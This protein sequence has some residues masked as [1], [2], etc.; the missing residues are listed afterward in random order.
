MNVDVE[1]GLGEVVEAEV[2]EVVAVVPHDVQTDV[3]V[4]EE[5]G[6][7][8]VRLGGVE[9]EVVLARAEVR[10]H[11]QVLSGEGLGAGNVKRQLVHLAVELQIEMGEQ[12]VEN[13]LLA[14][15]IVRLAEI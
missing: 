14:G 2:D 12:V 3:G 6:R 13:F 1:P 4:A 8:A 9:G 5:V 11:V 15:S 7:L 10:P